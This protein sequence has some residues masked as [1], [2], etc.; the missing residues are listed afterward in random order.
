ME[1]RRPRQLPSCKR[2]AA[3]D[4]KSKCARTFPAAWTAPV[5]TRGSA[6]EFHNGQIL[7]AMSVVTEGGVFSQAHC[8]R[9]V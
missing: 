3:P 5:R 4:G 8:L 9:S 2:P 7:S 1:V 6:N